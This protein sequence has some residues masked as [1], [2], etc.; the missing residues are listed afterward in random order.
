[1]LRA[2]FL[3]FFVEKTKNIIKIDQ[4]KKRHCLF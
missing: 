3:V 4:Q 1:M 2:Y